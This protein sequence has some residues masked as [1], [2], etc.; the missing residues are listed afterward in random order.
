HLPRRHQ[1]ARPGQAFDEPAGGRGEHVHRGAF[2][3]HLGQAVALVDVFARP[4]QPE[5]EANRFGPQLG[6]TDRDSEQW[7]HAG[8][9]SAWYLER[10]KGP[11]TTFLK[12]SSRA[13]RASSSNSSGGT[14]RAT[15]TCFSVGARYWPR[16]SVSQPA[17]RRSA[18]TPN[19]SSIVSPRPS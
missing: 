5:A 19:S 16:V 2:E 8:I 4:D 6:Q 11:A 15:G 7:D 12:P 1:V 14:K 9:S 17:A 18:S 10:T 3:Q 13:S